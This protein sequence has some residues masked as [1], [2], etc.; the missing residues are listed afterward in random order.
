MRMQ[1]G[2]RIVGDLGASRG[3]GANEGGFAGIRKSKQSNIGKYLQLELESAM[4]AG[5]PGR[6]FTGRAVGARFEID[7]AETPFGSPREQ[8]DLV[9]RG[10]VSERFSGFRVREQG[11]GGHAQHDIIGTFAVALG[12][13]PLLAVPRAVNAREAVFDEGVDVSVGHRIDAAA[14]A[15]VPAVGP[16]ARHVLFTPEPDRPLP[17]RPRIH[18]YSPFFSH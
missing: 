5:F 9:V 6:C 11:A 14:A 1:G 15:A 4:L 12:A 8:C 13:A 10:E 18:L 17:P 2:K 16:A 3:D 7:V